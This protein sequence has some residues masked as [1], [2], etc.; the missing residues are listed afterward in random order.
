MD[1]N[2]KGKNNKITAR[3]RM[4]ETRGKRQMKVGSR[5]Y[6]VGRKKLFTAYCL[7]LTAYCLLL[8]TPAYGADK[9]TRRS[10]EPAVIERIIKVEGTIER[11]RVIFIVPMSKLWKDDIFKKSF[12][13][14]ILK[15]IYPKFAI[16][17]ED[18][19]KAISEYKK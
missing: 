3:C 18:R 2:S 5:Q 19:T 16:N 11:P 13:D 14:D 15:P 9:G 12:V 6:A 4:Q 8:S 1:R 10:D 17:P 7:L